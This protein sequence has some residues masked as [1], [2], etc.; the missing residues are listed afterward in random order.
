MK[1]EERSAWVK[2]DAKEMEGLEWLLLLAR[3][4]ASACIMGPSSVRPMCHAASEAL[5][6]AA[7]KSSDLVRPVHKSK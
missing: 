6:T 3:R 7:S 1:M 5:A 4:V 2:T